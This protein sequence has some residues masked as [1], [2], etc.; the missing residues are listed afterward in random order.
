[1][2]RSSNLAAPVDVSQNSE[3]GDLQTYQE[4]LKNLEELRKKLSKKDQ[5]KI[6]ELGLKRFRTLKNEDNEE[7][8]AKNCHSEFVRK[9]SN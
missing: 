9:N 7:E 1:M 6:E 5:A 3:E 4:M 2:E 8:I